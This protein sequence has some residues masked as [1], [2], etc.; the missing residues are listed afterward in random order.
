MNRKDQIEVTDLNE[1]ICI[2]LD[3]KGGRMFFTDLGGSVYSVRL[4]GPSRRMLLSGQGVLTG[5]VY[6]DLPTKIK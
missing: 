1:G 3:L 6:V 2:A 5:I 4:D